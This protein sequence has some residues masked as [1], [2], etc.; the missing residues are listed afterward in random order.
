MRLKRM[1][2]TIT[3]GTLLT[4]IFAFT[5]TSHFDSYTSIRLPYKKAGLTT[6]QAAAH[7][8]NRF[9]FGAKPGEVDAVVAQGVENWLE[10][11][12]KG[13][14]ADDELNTHLQTTY[15]FQ[16]SQDISGQHFIFVF[17]NH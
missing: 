2:K 7:L 13:K 17:K 10:A 9:S 4:V 12:L 8:L 11:Q 15:R 16:E 1:F 3:I 6:Q 5:T 14:E